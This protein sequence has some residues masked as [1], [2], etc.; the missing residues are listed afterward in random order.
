MPQLSS[1]ESTRIHDRGES[2]VQNAFT[3]AMERVKAEGKSAA[4]ISEIKPLL[5]KAG[6]N[7]NGCKR[8]FRLSVD[9]LYAFYALRSFTNTG[10]PAQEE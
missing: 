9:E 3:Q 7:Q 8:I 6:F 2:T 4:T 1:I 10:H 5:V